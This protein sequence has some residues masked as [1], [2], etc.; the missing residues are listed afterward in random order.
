MKSVAIY[1]RVSTVRKAK[2]GSVDEAEIRKQNPEVQ[3]T[4][5]RAACAHRGIQIVEEYVDSGVSGA[6]ESRPALDRLM[7]D[8]SAGK[9]DGVMVVRFDRFARSTKHLLKALETFQS[10][11]IDFVSLSEGID[12]STPMGKMIFTMLSAIGEFERSLIVDRTKAGLAYTRSK[13]TRLGAAPLSV[14]TDRYRT[15]RA[16]GLSNRAIAREM[17]VCESVLRRRKIA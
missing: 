13:G 15:L 16:T 4:E 5:L 9:F 11:H 12:T 14:D 7:T 3:L 8:A 10:L 1:A 2:D 6:K 17:N